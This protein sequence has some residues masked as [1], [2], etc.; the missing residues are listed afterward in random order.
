MARILAA[1][2]S[3][4]H[5]EQLLLLTRDLGDHQLVIVT[6]DPSQA[7]RRGLSRAV[8][9]QDCNLREPVRAFICAVSSFALVL[10][11]RPDVVISTGA[12]SGFFCLLWGRLFGART[13]WIDSVANADR[14]SLSGRLARRVTKICLTQWE[15]LADGTQVRFAGSVL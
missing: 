8:F 9:L 6:T 15:H 14:L 13:L 7:G 5:L 4:G 12:A 3:G 2:S 10:R 11:I 1:A